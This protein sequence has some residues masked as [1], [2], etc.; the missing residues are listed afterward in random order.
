MK[1]SAFTEIMTCSWHSSAQSYIPIRRDW[2]LG[3]RGNSW[4][5]WPFGR[6]FAGSEGSEGGRDANVFEVLRSRVLFLA[7][8]YVSKKVRVVPSINRQ[9]INRPIRVSPSVFW[10]L[11]KEPYS[12]GMLNQSWHVKAMG[13]PVVGLGCGDC[14][15]F[16]CTTLVQ[17]TCKPYGIFIALTH[18]CRTYDHGIKFSIHI[19][20]CHL[21]F[22]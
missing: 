20:F 4:L 5:K 8:E 15:H 22:R 14:S 13:N 18:K 7:L 11:K 17:C 16:L 10:R 2:L 1:L 9:T 21:K 3:S 6:F 12:G 19:H